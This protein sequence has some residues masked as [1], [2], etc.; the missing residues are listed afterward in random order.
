MLLHDIQFKKKILQLYIEKMS[1][2]VF[3]VYGVYM[4]SRCMVYDFTVYGV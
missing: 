2:Y 4:I 1:L 3:T